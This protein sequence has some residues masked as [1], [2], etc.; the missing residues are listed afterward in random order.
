MRKKAEKFFTKSIP[1]L[2]FVAVMAWGLYAYLTPSAF[3]GAAAL[4]DSNFSTSLFGAVAGSGT[5]L[6]IEWVSGQYKKLA[7]FNAVLAILTAHLDTLINTKRQFSLP[8]LQEILS[9]KKYVEDAYAFQKQTG[10]AVEI[11]LSIKQVTQQ[12]QASEN[13]FLVPIDQVSAYSGRDPRV[14]ILLIRTKEA[15][16]ALNTIIE[17]KNELVME[18][19]NDHRPNDERIPIYLGLESDGGMVDGRLQ[20]YCEAILETNDTALFFVIKAIK[21]VSNLGRNELPFWLRWRVIDYK[22]EKDEIQEY[23]PAENYIEG[24]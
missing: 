15:L 3:E 4:F 21:S 18:M 17:K 20:S 12:I 22:I 23:L 13:E 6:L 19:M 2:L 7:L 5:V 8:H 24:W 10:R 14:L 1:F 16:R 9:I 11:R